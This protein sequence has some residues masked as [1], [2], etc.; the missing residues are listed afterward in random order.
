MSNAAGLTFSIEKV[1][2]AL[3]GAETTLFAVRV[4][5]V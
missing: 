3:D 2:A 5:A 4:T 1:G